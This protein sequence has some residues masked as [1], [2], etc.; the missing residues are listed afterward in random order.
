MTCNKENTEN[1]QSMS[2]GEDVKGD[3][4]IEDNREEGCGPKKRQLTISLLGK[5][6]FGLGL[7]HSLHPSLNTLNIPAK[8]SARKSQ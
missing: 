6:S 4:E 1:Q 5:N 2:P 8:V 3:G 7:V